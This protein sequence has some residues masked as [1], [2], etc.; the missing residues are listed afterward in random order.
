MV[1]INLASKPEWLYDKSPLGK[2]PA[3][4]LESGDVLYESLII[5][6]YLDEKYSQN[7]LHSSDPLQKAKDK[8]LIDQ[9][10][11]VRQRLTL[12][13]FF[14]GCL[15]TASI[16]TIIIPISIVL[17]IISTMYKL[18]LSA[19]RSFFEDQ[20]EIILDGLE[21]FENELIRRKG[22][23]F[24]GDK[25]GMLDYMIWPWC[26]RADLLKLFGNKFSIR[27]D[28]YKR[29]VSIYSPSKNSSNTRHNYVANLN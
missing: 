19:G 13:S 9:F 14:L 5:C 8:L 25:P 11:K 1:Y 24:N 22:P 16:T 23:F 20:E 21:T 6:D 29:L 10:S 17:Q 12:F 2:V 3:L 4:E 18:V 15:K 26:E 7:R 28:K 27:K